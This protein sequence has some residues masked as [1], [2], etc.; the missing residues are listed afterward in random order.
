MD[1]TAAL[2]EHLVRLLTWR[3]AHADFDAAVTGMPPDQMGVRPTGLPYS[4]WELLEHMRIAQRDILDFCRDPE[5]T[6]PKWPDDYWPPSPAPPDGG[7][8]AASVAAFKADRDAMKQLAADPATDLFA[9]IPH[10]EG[11]TYL[12][13]ILLVADHTAYHVGQLVIARRLL[14]TWE[15]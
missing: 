13:E 3:D 15:T 9:T 2:R 10:G 8:W 11:Q 12:R 6:A 4:P 7:A 1:P 14:G 5:Y